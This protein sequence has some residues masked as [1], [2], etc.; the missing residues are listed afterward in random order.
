MPQTRRSIFPL[1]L[2]LILLVPIAAA[3]SI[4]LVRLWHDRDARQAAVRLAQADVRLV[5]REMETAVRERQAAADALARSSAILD[6][7]ERGGA[8]SEAALGEIAAVSSLFPRST[9]LAAVSA[10]GMLYRGGIPAGSLGA[11]TASDAW[12][13]AEPGGQR[14]SPAAAEEPG[15][16]RTAVVLRRA[17]RLLGAVAVEASAAE[18]AAEVSSSAGPGAILA[19][20]D[21]VGTILHLAGAAAAGARTVSDI[22]PGIERRIFIEAMESPST[23]SGLRLFGDRAGGLPVVIA[24]ARLAVADWRLFVA[25]PVEASVPLMREAALAGL[26]L[27]A[28]ALLLLWIGLVASRARRVHAEELAHEKWKLREATTGLEEATHHAREA[29]SAM[30]RLAD[31]LRRAEEEA[32]A[33]SSA[34][35]EVRPLVVRAQELLAQ[36]GGRLAR[37]TQAAGEAARAASA[38]RGTAAEVSLA[39]GRAE[40]ELA[41]LIPAAGSTARAAA[42]I[43]TR[44]AVI[45]S[46]ADKARLLALNASVDAARGGEGMRKLPRAV[47]EIQELAGQAAES[48]RALAP[49]CA[50]TVR[51]AEA[52]MA[53]AEEGGRAA[54]AAVEGAESASSSMQQIDESVRGEVGTQP[55]S[56]GAPGA[57]AGAASDASLLDRAGSA[58]DGLARINARIAAALP[59]IDSAAA[60]AADACDRIV[61]DA[62]ARPQ[63]D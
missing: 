56:G 33:A 6:W 29:R 20:T 10:D 44:I 17:G 28:L 47:E 12:Y 37:V 23:A 58:L 5:A 35:A 14:T 52:A 11:G 4:L 51:D 19:L 15:I 8:P 16:L 26:G 18:L 50:A 36:C 62:D 54:R 13:F 41:R 45:G 49:D 38:A 42:R 27:A 30:A 24:A 61:R 3:L 40:Q 22:F 55:D 48:A 39:A 57:G 34:A 2:P 60:E 59:D 21:D 43:R 9:V 1:L 53:S 25:E 63:S 46:L 31:G 7:L 32:R